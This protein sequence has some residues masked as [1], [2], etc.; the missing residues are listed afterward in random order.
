[1]VKRDTPKSI[2]QNRVA[3]VTG[4]AT[5]LGRQITLTLHE[6]GF[7]ICVHCNNSVISANTLVEELNSSRPESAFSIVQDL[8]VTNFAENITSMITAIS[9]KKRN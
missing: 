1:M 6:A 5:R 8:T 7:D 4:G 2:T 3:L 9:N